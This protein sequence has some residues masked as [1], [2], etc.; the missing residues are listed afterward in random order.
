MQQWSL[1]NYRHGHAIKLFERNLK[2]DEVMVKAVE[3]PEYN[4]AFS[5]RSVVCS[6]QKSVI[7]FFP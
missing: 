1:R 7:D 4:G 6:M 2:R 3:M 5:E